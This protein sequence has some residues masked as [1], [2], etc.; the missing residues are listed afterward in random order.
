MAI[1]PGEG[2]ELLPAGSGHANSR[3]GDGVLSA[4]PPGTEPNDSFV[5]DPENPVLTY[6]G[7]HSGYLGHGQR[8][9]GPQDQR[10]CKVAT[11]YLVYTSE[12]QQADIEVT[13]PILC[14]LY[15]ASQRVDTDFTAKLIDVHPE[16]YA[17]I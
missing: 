7:T 1:K 4:E 12:P 10:R 8:S 3:Y 15:A 13:G 5:Y 17:Q 6:G 16:G 2:Y 11:M 14:K 9:D